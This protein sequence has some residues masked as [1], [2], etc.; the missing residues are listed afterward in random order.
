M[1][2][3]G[4]ELV[5]K[6]AD[7]F[8]VSTD[9]LLGE[10]S[11]VIDLATTDI[12]EYIKA[13]PSQEN[14][15]RKDIRHLNTQKVTG[16]EADLKKLKSLLLRIMKD[17]KEEYAEPSTDI[18]DEEMRKQIQQLHN[19]AIN[20]KKNL[21]EETMTGITT[22]MIASLG[23]SEENISD[24]MYRFK[25]HLDRALLRTN[26]GKRYQ[27]GGCKKRDCYRRNY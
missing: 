16:T 18:S 12:S 27:Q 14:D 22:Q 4:H 8:G 21:T 5:I 3:I 1:K 2:S 25:N 10:T 7:Y 24:I 9:Y 11:S 26:A 19:E 20:Q 23:L 15:G 6:F 17:V 13:N